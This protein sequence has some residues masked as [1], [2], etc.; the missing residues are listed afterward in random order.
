MSIDPQLAAAIR[1]LATQQAQLE[2][3]VAALQNSHSIDDEID[4]IPGRR[5]FYPMVM[6][7]TFTAANDGLRG[8]AMTVTVT[9]DGPWIMTHFPLA[10]WKGSAPAAA[11]YFG[12]WRPI[13]SW[14]LPDQVIDQGIID[15]SYEISDSGSNRNFQNE[16]VPGGLLSRPDNMVQLPTRT[17][18]SPNSVISVT[19]TYENIAFDAQQTPCT[20]GLLYFV[21]PGFKIVNM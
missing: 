9:Q 20:S 12:M 13:Y 11:T 4:R 1:R 17:L 2:Q 16:A 21:L 3:A 10:A 5:V 7:Q 14:P 18:F 8:S 19:P 6:K 15:I